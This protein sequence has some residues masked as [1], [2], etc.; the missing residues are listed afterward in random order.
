M[1]K[2]FSPL[3]GAFLISNPYYYYHSFSCIRFLRQ[4]NLNFY[5]RYFIYCAEI[6]TFSLTICS[7]RLLS[8]TLTSK[9]LAKMTSKTDVTTSKRHADA[10]HESVRRHIQGP[11]VRRHFLAPVSHTEFSVEYA[12]G[13]D[14]LKRIIFLPVLQRCRFQQSFYVFQ[15]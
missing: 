9:R 7:F 1:A 8:P 13:S 3:H 2:I 5:M 14:L 11:G 15:T 12:K 10:M 4:L 6:Y